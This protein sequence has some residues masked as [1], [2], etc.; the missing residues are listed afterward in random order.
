MWMN[1]PE[2][3]ADDPDLDENS[4][5]GTNHPDPYDFLTLGSRS[6]E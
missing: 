4:D 5:A 6:A 3:Y 2:E 1:P